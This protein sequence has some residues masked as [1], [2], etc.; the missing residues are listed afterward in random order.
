MKKVF[1]SVGIYLLAFAYI[2]VTY[3]IIESL[4]FD[5]GGHKEIL[6]GHS[7]P[8]LLTQ[9][10][11]SNDDLNQFY[12]LI[13]RS[14]KKGGELVHCTGQ[15]CYSASTGVYLGSG[16]VGYYVIFPIEK[17]FDKQSIDEIAASI[18]A[19]SKK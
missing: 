12:E 1:S 18:K 16:Q 5:N 14:I 19:L 7:T 9:E 8:E 11:M 6:K 2:F 4:F 13:D 15:G 3:T 17:N 10:N